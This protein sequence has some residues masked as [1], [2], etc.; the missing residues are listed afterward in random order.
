[1]KI[2]ILAAMNIAGELFDSRNKAEGL[3]QYQNNIE[4]KAKSLSKK[5]LELLSKKYL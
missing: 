3:E 5:K 2:A 1:M 4:S